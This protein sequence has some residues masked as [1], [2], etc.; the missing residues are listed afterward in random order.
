MSQRHSVSDTAE[1]LTTSH[2]ISIA[3]SALSAVT[4]KIVDFLFFERK[5]FLH[6][7]D[8]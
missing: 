3:E 2:S 1:A 5:W 8:V 7:S 6:S 4:L